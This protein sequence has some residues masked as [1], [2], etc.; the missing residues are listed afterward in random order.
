MLEILQKHRGSISVQELSDMLNFRTDDIVKTLQAA[1]SAQRTRPHARGVHAACTRHAQRSTRH[2]C[3]ACALHPR[4]SIYMCMHV[5]AHAHDMHMRMRMHAHM[6]M[7]TLQAFNMIKYFGG[8][9]SIYVSPKTLATY[10]TDAKP[11]CASPFCWRPAA[12]QG[13]VLATDRPL[14]YSPH[15]LTCYS[16]PRRCT[17]RRDH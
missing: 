15:L 14:T 12:C 5:H 1:H 9:H 17:P 13:S 2:T 11:N 3:T 4:Y 7:C 16:P 8:Q 10:Y 6:H